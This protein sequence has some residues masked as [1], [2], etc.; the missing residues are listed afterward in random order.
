MD[1]KIILITD[2]LDSKAR[3]E[4]ELI[5]YQEELR[6]LEERMSYLRMEIKLTNDIIRLIENEKVQ[7][8]KK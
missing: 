2:L 5:F 6:K 4:K 8:I 3:K 7:E 1:A